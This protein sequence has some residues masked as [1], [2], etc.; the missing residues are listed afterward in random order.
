MP[1]QHLCTYPQGGCCR[2]SPKQPLL[3]VCRL[4]PAMHRSALH[5]ASA[6]SGLAA[7]TRAA[8]QQELLFCSMAF[9]SQRIPRPVSGPKQAEV[10]YPQPGQ[11][12]ELIW[13]HRG[14][15]GSEECVEK[16][17]HSFICKAPAGLGRA[18]TQRSRSREGHLH[19]ADCFGCSRVFPDGLL[20]C[21]AQQGAVGREQEHASW[22]M[23]P[24]IHLTLGWISKP[25]CSPRAAP[26]SFPG[27]CLPY[28][29]CIEHQP[30][31]HYP[32]LQQELPQPLFSIMPLS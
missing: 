22:G 5:L 19:K 25:F 13:I 15:L 2:Q 18:G 12:C 16:P 24:H 9:P 10:G 21:R 26:N 14:K 1:T 27:S 28:A 23:S 30:H 11:R 17:S 7:T 29:R 32:A 3:P 6:C 4:A 31:M 20:A 8:L